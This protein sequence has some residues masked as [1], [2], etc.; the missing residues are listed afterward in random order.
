MVAAIP[1]CRRTAV[2]FV[3]FMTALLRCSPASKP[4]HYFPRESLGTTSLLEIRM[5]GYRWTVWRH[6]SMKATAYASDSCVTVCEHVGLI[7]HI[8]LRNL[9]PF[10]RR[11]GFCQA[12]HDKRLLHHCIARV[13][14]R[15]SGH[16]HIVH[17]PYTT[18]IIATQ[19]KLIS[20]RSQELERHLPAQVPVV[21]N[22]Y[23][24]LFDASGTL[25][26]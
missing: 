22:K 26:W 20:Q 7:C 9:F 14:R 23:F 13:D 5:L 19:P 17:Q 1:P 18:N 24:S 6:S 2:S 12:L 11:R 21:G 10:I 4:A 15:A 25:T 3:A 8:P 16:K